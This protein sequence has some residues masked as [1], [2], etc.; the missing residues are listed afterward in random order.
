MLLNTVRLS[1]LTSCIPPKVKV[2]FARPVGAVMGVLALSDIQNTSSARPRYN[3]GQTI[4]IGLTVISMSVAGL[5][6]INSVNAKAEYALQQITELKAAQRQ[7]AL[8][9]RDDL[10]T[11]NNKVDQLLLRVPANGR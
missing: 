8:D 10:R 5:Q 4:G 3:W 7:S 6:Y 1:L 9:N 11:L 2:Y